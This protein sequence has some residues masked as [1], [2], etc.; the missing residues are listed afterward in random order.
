MESPVNVFLDIP[1]PPAKVKL[2]PL[3]KELAFVVQDE[4]KP[5]FIIRLPVVT[6]NDSIVSVIDIYLSNLLLKLVTNIIN[7]NIFSNFNCPQSK[8]LYEPN[9]SSIILDS[10]LF[11]LNPIFISLDFLYLCLLILCLLIKYE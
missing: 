8:I 5:P 11:S 2:P 4:L 6:F 1:I 3:V 9:S 10:V 7:Y